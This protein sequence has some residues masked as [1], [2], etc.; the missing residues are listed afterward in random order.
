M[1][2]EQVVV[3][4]VDEEEYAIPVAESKEII[5][6]QAVIERAKSADYKEGCI[7]VRGKNIPVVSLS[8]KFGL[9]DRRKLDQSVIIMQIGSQDIGI[10]VDEVME[11]RQL[12][13]ASVEPTPGVSNERG[14]CITG[15][16]KA[17]NR[18]IILLDLAQL[19]RREDQ[20]VCSSA[21]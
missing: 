6:H 2:Q 21:G 15:I 11:S 3:F 17:D 20:K 4:R 10:L 1:L 12:T 19:F 18:L 8:A 9:T 14:S 13:V 16:G 5:R 7:T